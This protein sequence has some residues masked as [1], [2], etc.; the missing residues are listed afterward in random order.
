M[1]EMLRPLVR[2]ESSDA[3]SPAA[4]GRGVSSLGAG[5]L[6]FAGVGSTQKLNP[7]CLCERFGGKRNAQFRRGDEADLPAEKALPVGWKGN[8]VPQGAWGGS[9]FRWDQ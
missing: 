5:A 9:G 4:A 8:G 2:M 3:R 1:T 6:S 7:P